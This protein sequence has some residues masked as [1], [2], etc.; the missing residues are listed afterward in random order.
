MGCEGAHPG[1][2]PQGLPSSSEDLVYTG[3]AQEG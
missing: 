1:P 2:Q 3:E